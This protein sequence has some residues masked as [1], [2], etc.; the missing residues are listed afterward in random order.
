M[1]YPNLQKFGERVKTKRYLISRIPNQPN[2][3]IKTFHGDTKLAY[4]DSSIDLSFDDVNRVMVTLDRDKFNMNKFRE[5]VAQQS[6]IFDM[7]QLGKE[8]PLI[9]NVQSTDLLNKQCQRTLGNGSNAASLKNIKLINEQIK[10][11]MM[12]QPY[13]WDAKHSI[14]NRITTDPLNVT[15]K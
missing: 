5:Q 9:E 3:S 14:K 6:G 11:S 12:R 7:N 2:Q 4:M 8:P 15:T 1:D 13:E 10:Q